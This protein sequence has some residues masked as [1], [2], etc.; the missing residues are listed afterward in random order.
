LTYGCRSL[1][2]LIKAFGAPLILPVHS[3]SLFRW[4]T[5]SDIS[6]MPTAAAFSRIEVL[7][8]GQRVEI[9]GLRP[10]DREGMLTPFG[11]R[12]P[13]CLKTKLSPIILF[14]Q[15]DVR[16]NPPDGE[17]L[18]SPATPPDDRNRASQCAPLL[19]W[20]FIPVHY[21]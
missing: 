2:D 16:Q 4:K 14:T 18:G 19:L 17:T 5:G 13:N 20:H 11:E 10:T 12:A 15:S 21:L 3:I 9:R 1:L 8:N 7:S 6:T